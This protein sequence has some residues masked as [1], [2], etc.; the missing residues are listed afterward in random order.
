G[1]GLHKLLENR[2][3]IDAFYYR[4]FVNGLD[5]LGSII[6]RFIEVKV[7]DGFNYFL[8]RATVAFVQVFRS[9]QTGESNINISGLILGL[10]ILL[11]LLLRVFFGVS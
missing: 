6:Y 2:Y 10:A 11:L 7:I 4:V 5:R 9:I 1:A 3:Y 8:S